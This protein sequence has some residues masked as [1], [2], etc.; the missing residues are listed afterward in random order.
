MPTVARESKGR[1]SCLDALGLLVG[2]QAS[3]TER[4]AAMA[5]GQ[6]GEAVGDVG[7]P[8]ATDGFVADAQKFCEFD[9]GVAQLDA[10]QGAEAQNL[11]GFIGQAGERLA[12]RIGMISLRFEAPRIVT[13]SVLGNFHAGV[14]PVRPG[15]K[16]R[17]LALLGEVALVVV[18][19]RVYPVI[20]QTV[21]LPVMYPAM[22]RLPLAS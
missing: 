17:T 14:I 22:V 19:V 16:Q 18:G 8:P 4:P 10:T 13:T 15:L 1:Y 21:V 20:E 5:V 12:T 2:Q 7:R 6:S 9:L 11:K 3:G